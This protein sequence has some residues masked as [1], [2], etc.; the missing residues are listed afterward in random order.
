MSVSLTFSELEMRVFLTFDLSINTIRHHFVLEIARVER[1]MQSC[2]ILISISGSALSIQYGKEITF[3]AEGT[4]F[5]KWQDKSGIERLI[6]WNFPITPNPFE[7]GNKRNSH[8]CQE[9]AF[10]SISYGLGRIHVK[11][12]GKDHCNCHSGY[13]HGAPGDKS[14]FSKMPYICIEREP[15][16]CSDKRIAG[17]AAKLSFKLQPAVNA[18]NP[19]LYSCFA[20]GKLK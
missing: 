13:Q 14:V 16:E 3:V 4:L 12:Q 20:G 15:T 6:R 5:M 7:Q 11:L 2:G 8:R 10:R 18:R 17:P 1:I 19:T 9:L